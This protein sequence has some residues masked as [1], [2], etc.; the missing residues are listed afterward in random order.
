[1]KKSFVSP[2]S[3]VAA[4]DVVADYDLGHYF[5]VLSNSYGVDNGYHNVRHG[6]HVM[7]ECYRAIRWYNITDFV[8]V[9]SFLI[10]ALLHDLNHPGMKREDSLNI[11]HTTNSIAS[12]LLPEDEQLS[13][14][15]SEYVWFTE[16][17]Q[18]PVPEN[19]FAGIIQDADRTQAFSGEGYVSEIFIGLAAEWG[20]SPDAKHIQ[21]QIDFLKS[22]SWKSD[23]AQHVYPQE[24]IDA[25]I[26][27]YQQWM[28]MLSAA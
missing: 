18:K 8:R 26:A 13:G 5:H 2:V 7:M 12:N 14:Q 28:Q 22:I 4:V 16:F 3:L 24:V 21:G 15:I 11:I 25:K 19:L 1:M 9:R 23:W 20:V 10:A 17:P 27:E 6:L